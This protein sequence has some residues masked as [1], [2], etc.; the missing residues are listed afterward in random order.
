MSSVDCRPAAAPPPQVQEPSTPQAMMKD[1]AAVTYTQQH[2]P[3]C[4]VPLAA[5]L[6]LSLPP[7]RVRLC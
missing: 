7:G 5:I 1:C 3:Y 4:G 6:R 2:R